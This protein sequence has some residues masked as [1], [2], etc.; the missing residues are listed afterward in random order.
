MSEDYKTYAKI[1]CADGFSMSVQAS[2]F[3]CCSPRLTGASVYS[4]VEVGFPSA[5]VESLMPYCEDRH[6]PTDTVYGWV[7]VEIVSAIIANHGGR[8]KGEAPPGVIITTPTPSRREKT[9]ISSTFGAMPQL[10]P[11]ED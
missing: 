9:S 5:R 7:P 3:T 2:S 4:E 1:I 10:E 8:V 6:N 11:P